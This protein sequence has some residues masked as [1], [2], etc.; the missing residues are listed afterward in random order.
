MKA[1]EVAHILTASANKDFYTDEMTSEFYQ[2]RDG[3]SYPI[4]GYG[5]VDA[6]AAMRNHFTAEHAF[7]N[8]RVKQSCGMIASGNNDYGSNE[9]CIILLLVPAFLALLR[10]GFLR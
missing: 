10:K 3:R 2:V 7:E 6:Y 4:M 5:V 8:P 9:I 1:E